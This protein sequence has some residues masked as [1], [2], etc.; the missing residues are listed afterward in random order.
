M[1]KKTY[2][3]NLIMLLDEIN[4][5]CRKHSID[6]VCVDRLAWDAFKFGEYH[7]STHDAF[8]AICS[9][10]EEAFKLALEGNHNRCFDSYRNGPINVLRYV[11]SSSFYYDVLD[12]RD[13]KKP[14]LA[15]DVYLLDFSKNEQ[16]AYVFGDNRM[17]FNKKDLFPGQTKSFEGLQLPIPANADRFFSALVSP[18]WQKSNYTGDIRRERLEAL[19]D[20][21]LPFEIALNTPYFPDLLFDKKFKHRK[22]F[23]HIQA[24]LR[25]LKQKV[26]RYDRMR[27]LTA[28]RFYHWEQLYPQ[29]EALQSASE[30][31]RRV[32]LN[33]YLKDVYKYTKKYKLGLY[34]NDE[35]L[36]FSKPI[37][38]KEKGERFFS[39]YE[40]LIPQNHKQDVG[41]QMSLAG[42]DHPL[43]HR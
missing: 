25:P 39:Q 32:I 40:S 17:I 8:I 37:I 10:D 7:D 29:M 11:D 14:G 2:Q 35:I 12:A 41:E 16:C 42:I 3:N 30:D 27:R 28:R 33:S 20:P 6:F 43:F 15:V 36:S 26:D 18:N 34:V 24:K 5:A 21:S 19:C 13:I 23:D 38:I 9:E 4:H 1:M 31:E 22:V